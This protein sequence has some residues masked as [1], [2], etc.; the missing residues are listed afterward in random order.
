VL[1]KRVACLLLPNVSFGDVKG[2]ISDLH[3]TL[4]TNNHDLL[5]L[6]ETIAKE[7][8]LELKKTSQRSIATD[9]L[10]KHVKELSEVLHPNT[11]RAP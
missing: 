3:R 2:P 10:V 11:F 8:G 1:K 9:A 4:L 6:A 7:T 5:D